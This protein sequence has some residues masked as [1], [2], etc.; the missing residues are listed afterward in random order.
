MVTRTRDPADER[1]VFTNLPPV[2]ESIRDDVWSISDSIKSDCK[3]HDEEL[4]ALRDTLRS[5]ACP[6]KR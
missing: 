2:G 6:A 5:L 4:V 1:R 3:T